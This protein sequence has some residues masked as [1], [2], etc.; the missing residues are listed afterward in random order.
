MKITLFYNA[1][2]LV[3]NDTLPYRGN[4]KCSNNDMT[5]SRD[6]DIACNRGMTSRSIIS[7]SVDIPSCDSNTGSDNAS[8]IAELMS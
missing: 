6:I 8:K 4:S 1:K 7:A 3:Y 5:Y 2:I